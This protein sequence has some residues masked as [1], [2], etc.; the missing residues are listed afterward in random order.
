MVMI[1]GGTSARLGDMPTNEPVPEATYHLRLDKAELKATGAGSKTPGAPMAEVQFTI[2]GP[3]EAE[4]FHGRKIFENLMLTGSG[5]FRLRQLLEASGEN[6]D[7]ILEDTD[8]L[9]G[10]EVAGVVQVQ[11]GRKDPNTGTDYPDRNRIARFLP[12]E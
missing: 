12:I 4:E 6:E 1:P 2:F 10:R 3:D 7:F 5:M 11:K 9:L 8:Q